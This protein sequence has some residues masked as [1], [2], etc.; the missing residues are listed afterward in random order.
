MNDSTYIKKAADFARKAH[1]GQKRKD[2][3]EYFTHVEAVANI[4]HDNWSVEDHQKAWNEYK[5]DV[6]AAAY[7]HDTIEDCG[8]TKQGLID[9]GFPHQN[10]T[11]LC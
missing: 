4:V 9:E 6:I 5:D 2:G 11:D 7:L 10:A 3:K 8:V 1:E